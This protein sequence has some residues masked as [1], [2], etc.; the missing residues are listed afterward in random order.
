MSDQQTAVKRPANEIGGVV[1]DYGEVLCFPPDRS[2]Q[3]RMAAALGLDLDVFS[4]NYQRERGSYDRGDMSP[5]EYWSK[6]AAGR[7]ALNESL[8]AKLR[9]WDVEMWSNLNHAM[10]DWLGR[11][12]RAGFKTGVLSNMH[13][14]MASFVHR[15][16]GWLGSLDCLI[17]SCEVRLVKPERAIYDRCVDGLALP[18]SEVLFID[19]RE[20]NVKAAKDAGLRAL[21]FES[22]EQLREA[23]AGLSFP[24]LPVVRPA[25]RERK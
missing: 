19:D 4:L 8:L 11:L 20:V 12:R 21:Q 17:L 18:P 14:D 10:V 9:D 15:R 16:F 6:V 5:A 24:D 25:G 2:Q 1:L 23:L 3:A 7:D 22:I 13:A